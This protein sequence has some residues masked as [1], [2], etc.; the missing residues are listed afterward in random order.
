VL[1]GNDD[2]DTRARA[3]AEGAA[4]Y[5][6]KLPTKN[7]LVACI[8]RHAPGDGALEVETG[9]AVV[10]RPAAQLRPDTSE[11]LDRSMIADFQHADAAGVSYFTRTLIDQFLREATSQVETLRN[12]VRRS[13]APALKATAHS[14]K[15]SSMT[16]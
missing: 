8:R 4:D 16:M 3:L 9:P 15:G 1:S 6:V 11:T 14:L 12:A 5:L 10:D 2:A 13:D 7:A